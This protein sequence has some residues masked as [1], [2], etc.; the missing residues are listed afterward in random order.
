MSV[1]R[2]LV[3]L[4]VVA[5][6]GTGLAGCSK[7]KGPGGRHGGGPHP[8]AM[9][10]PNI[11]VALLPM[12]GGVER[13]AREKEAD[14]RFIAEVIRQ[15]GSREEG[16]RRIAA[17]G[18]ANCRRNDFAGAILRFNQAWLLD[19]KNPQAYWGF[20]AVLQHESKLDKAL[21]MVEKAYELAP[22]DIRLM[23]DLAYAYARKARDLRDPILKEEYFDKS[24]RLFERA[25]RLA[26]E[27]GR[28]YVQMAMMHYLRMQ[29]DEAW[30]KL[31]EARRL[32]EKDIDP[33]FVQALAR[34]KADPYADEPTTQTLLKVEP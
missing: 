2:S 5:V 25:L 26:P 27:N 13:T 24:A 19:P 10:T 11:Q 14:A 20:G 23:G 31:H 1:C 30:R 9:A 15:A 33:Y 8:A 29:Y 34:K 4:A 3:W 32:G 6:V 21:E 17:I 22:D 7:P 12:Y 28:L 16:S 18:W